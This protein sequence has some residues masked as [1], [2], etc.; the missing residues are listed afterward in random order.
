ME[1][2][3]EHTLRLLVEEAPTGLLLVD[4]RGR[5]FRVNA[6]VE[7]LTGYSRAELEGRSIE[8]LVP[9]SMRQG[10][11]VQRE[12][13]DARP[14]RRPLGTGLN[15][16]VLRKDGEEVPVDISLTPLRV[17][18]EPMTLAALMDVTPRHNAE[19]ATREAER[20][21]F[22]SLSQ[23]ASFVAHQVNTP[24]TN[25]SLLASMIGR[26]TNDDKIRAHAE[27]IHEQRRAAADIIKELMSIARIQRLDRRE[28]DLRSVLEEAVEAVQP[29]IP[30]SV[31]LVPEFADAPVVL[32]VDRLQMKEA[33][34]NLLKNA[35][36]ATPSGTVT[37][38][39]L[40]G[41]PAVRVVVEDT[42]I[43][44]PPDVLPKLFS[45]FFTTKPGAGTGLGLAYVKGVVTAHGGSVEVASQLGDGSTFTLVLPGH[46]GSAAES[47][48]SPGGPGG[49]STA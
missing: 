19:L 40:N 29:T 5:I 47:S 23:M 3:D 31:R 42:G 14:V 44:I 22:F 12:R 1:N 13:Y 33:I 25:I 34:V 36:E 45:P 46:S 43:G 39:L 17:G 20:R 8:D 11:V 2:L 18:G 41:G 4:S 27:K 32:P 35:V 9:P 24:L 26:E 21:A 48:E 15:L 30:P 49:A 6:A 10:H 16:F 37:V 7:R 38:R 28:T